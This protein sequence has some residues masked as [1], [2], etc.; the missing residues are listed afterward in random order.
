MYEVIYTRDDLST[1]I[2]GN[3]L[4][5]KWEIKTPVNSHII[6]IIKSFISG[7]MRVYINNKIVAIEEEFFKK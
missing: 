7:Q 4:K 5:L 6:E 2:S 1:P 3:K